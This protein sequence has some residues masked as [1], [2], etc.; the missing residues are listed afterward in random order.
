[1]KEKDVD[2]TIRH[3]LIQEA[4][5]DYYK[6]HTAKSQRI[7]SI[8]SLLRGASG[9]A[10]LTMAA[11]NDKSWYAHIKQLLDDAGKLAFEIPIGSPID[12]SKLMGIPEAQIDVNDGK[13][14]KYKAPGWMILHYLNTIPLTDG[15]ASGGLNNAAQDIFAFV[16]NDNSGST[17]YDKADYM[18]YLLALDQGYTFH[19]FLIKLYSLLNDYKAENWTYGANLIYAL[20]FDYET[21]AGHLAGFRMR[22]NNFAKKLNT[23]HVPKKFPLYERSWWLPSVICKDGE[24]HRSQNYTLLPDYI[25]V[26]DDT[27][28]A[29]NPLIALGANKS[30]NLPPITYDQLLTYLTLFESALSN[31]QDFGTMSGDTLKAYGEGNLY[32]LPLI[33]GDYHIESTYDTEV[34]SQIMNGTVTGRISYNSAGFHQ[35]FSN[36]TIYQGEASSTTPFQK[37]AGIHT[38]YDVIYTSNTDLTNTGLRADS[39][40][41]QMLNMLSDN[42]TTPEDLAVATRLMCFYTTTKQVTSSGDSWFLSASRE[43]THCGTEI[44]TTVDMVAYNPTNPDTENPSGT[45]YRS[46]SFSSLASRF[47]FEQSYEVQSIAYQPLSYLAYLNLMSFDWAPEIRLYVGTFYSNLNVYYYAPVFTNRDLKQFRLYSSDE[48]DYINTAAVESLFGM[49]D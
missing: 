10:G 23:F 22:I 17:N 20:G 43:I 11:S 14:D 25:L 48:F 35:D 21:F 37:I 8:G 26:Y 30:A 24:V 6:K 4:L 19:G 46:R 32:T 28:G 41:Y 47:S 36:G 27:T 42:E 13:S 33:D 44:L 15:E 7:T 29:L 16:R 5:D 1:M 38:S 18:M 3:N 34:L 31:S 39:H 2:E 12:I 45:G 49:G 9:L 40:Q